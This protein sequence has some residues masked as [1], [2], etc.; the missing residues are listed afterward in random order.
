MDDVR[1]LTLK[2]LRSIDPDII[3]D[4]LQI[5]YYQSFK[6]RFDVFGEFQN[7][8]GLFEFAI[9]FDK[10]GNLKRKHINMISP[11]NLRSDLEKKIYKK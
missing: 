3:E 1:S 11:K 8:I 7:K 5:K 6:D 2:V 9:S 4:T 10:K